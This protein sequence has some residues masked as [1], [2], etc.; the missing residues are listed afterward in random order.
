[1][2]R[3]QQALS[4]QVN[5]STTDCQPQMIPQTGVKISLSM[6]RGFNV[7]WLVSWSFQVEHLGDGQVRHLQQLF[8][9][10]A[11]DVDLVLSQDRPWRSG[12]RHC[13]WRSGPRE[14][15][16]T[17]GV[18]EATAT[19]EKA[20]QAPTKSVETQTEESCLA[21]AR[22]EPTA[23]PMETWSLVSEPQTTPV[24]QQARPSEEDGSD[25]E[26]MKALRRLGRSVQETVA[27]MQRHFHAWILLVCCSTA[28]VSPCTAYAW[29][30]LVCCFTGACFVLPRSL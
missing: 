3:R 27:G 25:G 10:G 23:E 12:P 16:T 29:I 13:P 11:G 5:A 2:A 18:E 30:L 14:K 9:R 7:G 28:V 1:M 20:K 17:R 4:N 26:E 6:A 24:A 21:G 22:P 19:A 15:P 8:G